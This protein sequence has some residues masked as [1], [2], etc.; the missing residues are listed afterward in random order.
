MNHVALGAIEHILIAIAARSRADI[1]QRVTTGALGVGQA[2]SLRRA[3]TPIAEGEDILLLLACVTK[4]EF[5]GNE[6]IGNSLDIA[7]ASII[8]GEGRRQARLSEGLH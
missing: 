1:G 8:F 2:S 6:R 7:I 3:I 4:A 5:F